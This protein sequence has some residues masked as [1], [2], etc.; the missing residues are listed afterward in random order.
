MRTRSEGFP[1]ADVVIMTG[2]A[3]FGGALI[4][5]ATL[6]PIVVEG[7]ILSIMWGWFLVPFGL[8]HVSVPWA[9]GLVGV[10][11]IFSNTTP[12]LDEDKKNKFALTVLAKPWLILLV[13]YIAKQFM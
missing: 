9:I 10:A 4:A 6:L 5:G 2:L 7:F 11:G 13:G 3:A 8:P 1:V 12:P